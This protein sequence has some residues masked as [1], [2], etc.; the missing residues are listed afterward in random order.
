MPVW[1]GERYLRA[2]LDSVFAQSFADF[3]LVV[4]DDG[5]TDRTSDILGSY[6]DSRLITHRLEHAGIVTALNF[7]TSVARGEWIAR[8]DADDISQPERLATQMKAVRARPDAVLSYTDVALVGED[9]RGIKPARFPRTKA[10]LALR[11]CYQNPIC[12]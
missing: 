5:S 9:A 12:T 8:Q 10:F 2:A 4:V 11:L 3:E 6:S 7:G 1:N